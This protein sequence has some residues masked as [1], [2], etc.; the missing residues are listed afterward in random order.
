MRVLIAEDDPHSRYMLAALLAGHGWEVV[1]AS[2]GVEALEHVRRGPFD[3]VMADL[4]MPRLDGFQLCRTIKADSNLRNIPILV[5]TATYTAPADEE[6]AKAAG[7]DSVLIKPAE[8]AHILT[9]V[10][11]VLKKCGD[12]PAPPTSGASPDDESSTAGLL[13]ELAYVQQHNERLMAKLNRKLDQLQQANAQLSEREARFRALAEAAPVGILRLDATGH[14]VYCNDR[15][16]RMAGADAAGDW[17]AAVH[18]HDQLRARRFWEQIA[19]AG[20]EGRCELRLG[21]GASPTCVLFQVKPLSTTPTTPQGFLIIVTDVTA[22]KQLQQEKADLS[23]RLHLTQ[24]LEALGTLVSGIAHEFNNVLTSILGFSEVAR[25]VAGTPEQVQRELGYVIEA[26]RTGRELTRQVLTFARPQ[27]DPRTAVDLTAVVGT[28]IKLVRPMVPPAIQ[29]QSILPERLPPVIGA[30]TQI[31]QVV[32]NLAKNALDAM[33]KSGG[34]LTIALEAQTVDAAAATAHADLRPGDYVVLSVRDTGA[35]IP[36]DV[37]PRI[38]DPFFTTKAAGEGTG[39]GLSVVHGIVREH[40]GAITV[41]S[42]P[43]RGTLFSVFF[44]VARDMPTA[45]T[46]PAEPI[47]GSGQHVLFIDD[48]SMH[49][50][51]AERMFE[52]LGYRVTTNTDPLAALEELRRQPR[53]FD[54]VFTDYLMPEIN[55]MELAALIAQAR[56]ELPVVLVTATTGAA[57]ASGDHPPAVAG[58]LSKPFDMIELSQA[59]ARVLGLAEGH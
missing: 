38:F 39:L 15:W 54:L 29:L 41:S 35:G 44:P 14:A 32:V 48:D 6:L 5:Y 4:L 28:A 22:E 8:P 36:T 11:E 17:T 24:K 34:K 45:V 23:A 50:R 7:A 25:H 47:P 16:C 10:E 30:D 3:L 18:P 12:R 26:A 9:A 57:K 59:A 33:A 27:A 20:Y 56:P 40:G 21:K 31:Q 51:L 46:R 42:E 1:T 49:C 52:R 37:L 58:I 13:S 43:G 55:G 2:D 19:Q 53:R